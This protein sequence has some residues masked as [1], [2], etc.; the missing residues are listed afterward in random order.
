VVLRCTG[1]AL[2]YLAH[3]HDSATALLERALEL[4]PN[5]AEVHHSAGW[6]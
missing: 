6:V 5:S 1:H 2:A 3:E 4:H